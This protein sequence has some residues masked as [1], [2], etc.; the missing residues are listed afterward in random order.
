MR[1]DETL[2]GAYSYAMADEEQGPGQRL[3]TLLRDRRQLL[4]LSQ[5]D[6]AD[7]AGVSRQT[8]IRLESGKATNPEAKTLRAVCTALGLEVRE[9]LIELGYVTRDEL[10]LPPAPPPIDPVLVAV[11][12]D[13]A[14]SSVDEMDRSHLRDLT[15]QAHD[16]WRSRRGAARR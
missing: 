6:V 1:H 11:S 5:D 15:R 2:D 10:G 4:E 16:Y 3:R 14:D 7:L 9:A 8:V 12:R 13:L